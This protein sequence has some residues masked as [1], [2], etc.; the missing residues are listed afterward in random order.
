M[1]GPHPEQEDTKGNI[2]DLMVPISVLT[3]G[4]PVIVRDSASQEFCMY[5]W[6]HTE[7]FLNLFL[8]FIFHE[9]YFYQQKQKYVNIKEEMSFLY[10]WA[11][12]FIF[13]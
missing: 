8:F 12:T 5:R 7:I 11:C 3:N 6:K 10:F 4:K 9:I 13:H 2:S 1:T